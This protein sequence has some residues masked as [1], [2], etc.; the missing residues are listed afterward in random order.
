MVVLLSD[1]RFA[2]RS[3]LRTP[4][5]ALLVLA[6]LAIGIGATTAIFS[7]VNAVLLRP[8]TFRDANRL[9][10]LWESNEPRGWQ[11]VQVAPANALDWRERVRSFADV[12]LVSEFTNN[13]ALAGGREVTLVDVGEMSG[14]G[15]SVLGAT[16]AL[17]RTFTIQETWAD[18][19]PVLV[20]SHGMWQRAFGGDSG[21]VGRTVRLDGVAHRVIGVMRSDF[22]YAIS[23]AGAWRTFRWTDARRTSV[24][25]RQAH[26]VRA[27]AR[28]APGVSE[29]QA[30]RELAN[31]AAQLEAEHPE[32]NRDMKAGFTPLHRFLVGDQRFPLLLLL[33]AVLLLQLIVCANVANLL[34][35]RAV[36][37]RQE[38]A[39][40]RALGAGRGRIARQ[41]MT[42]SLLLAAAGTVAGLLVA[43]FGLDA[44]AGL[45]PPSLPAFA[46]AMDWRMLLFC[47]ST[48]VLSALLFGLQPALRSARGDVAAELSDGS[49]TGTVGRRGFFAAH[50]L[51]SVEIAMAVM[52][53]VGAGLMVRSLAKLRSVESGVNPDNVLTFAIRP[54]SGLYRTDDERKELTLRLLAQL[55]TLPGVREAGAGRQL[56]FT[57]VGWSSDFTMEGWAAD[58]FGVEVRHRE[59]T[60]GYFRA[61]EVPVLDGAL[62]QEHLVPGT[63]VPVVV[64][65]AF[66]DRYFPGESPVG[67][68]VTFD[69]A[70]TADSYWYRIVAVVGNERMSLNTEPVPEIIAHLQGDTPAV[71]QFVVKAEAS[72]TSLVPEIRR[73]V[74]RMAPEVPLMNV[75]TMRAVAVD[76]IAGDRFVMTLLGAF[77]IA[78][79]VLAAVGV[80]GVASQVARAR[81]KEIGIRLAL[82]ATTADVAR[83]LVGRGL[84]FLAVGVAGG[85]A[86]AL[87]A[88][89]VLRRL[90]FR[91]EPNDPVTLAAV[92]SLLTL[93]ALVASLIPARRAA[94]V[95]PVEVLNRE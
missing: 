47:V 31:V 63:G 8:L 26:V 61:L 45:R 92:A 59:V 37:R 52:L 5:F 86:G 28:L 14:N 22:Q 85:V 2:A 23:G 66:V 65:R 87:A 44:V 3:L 73:T 79:L 55:R 19:E 53:V 48:A 41:V 69:R 10:M 81:T 54:P 56:P 29:E 71:M 4:R 20:L 24:W 9:V 76:A 64:N 95:D 60:P 40:R 17:G 57:G 67:R 18:A 33:G 68:R 30:R 7:A 43:A 82:G 42:E 27:V 12:A 25:F 13:V 35:A 11:Q 74:A 78:A 84:G 16:P 72:P 83:T 62:F 75:R 90:L 15:F 39:V 6:T 34:S 49:R 36:A 46:V 80:Y 88:G 1:L 21:V 89:G 94:R 32:T 50:S 70:S 58:R 38:M 51:V 93:V 77:A 91:V